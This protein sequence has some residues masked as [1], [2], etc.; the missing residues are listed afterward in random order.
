M[1]PPRRRY[2]ARSAEPEPESVPL[3]KPTDPR[4]DLLDE[5]STRIG[6]EFRDPGL[7]R[8][9]LVHSSM[10]NEGK[11][12]YERLEFLGDAILGF[13]VADHLFRLEPEI[14]EGELTD[15]R[16][17]IVSREPLAAIGTAL[18]LIDYV[19]VGR[20]LRQEE[21]D[22]P[23]LRADL[24]EA[25]LG[26]VYLDGGIR[27]ARRFLRQH[28]LGRI[29]AEPGEDPALGRPRDPKSRL[30]HF[31]QAKAL[32]QPVYSVVATEGPDHAKEF[33][34]AVRIAEAELATG[35][36]RSKQAAQMAAAEAALRIL[37]ARAGEGSEGEGPAGEDPAGEVRPSD[38]SD[39]SDRTAAD[40]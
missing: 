28:V 26:A 12:S 32:G 19:E 27:A 38:P 37:R 25:V 21:L 17:R 16:A 3:T 33:T 35:R 31:A 18:R 34:V 6:H 40:G 20:G 15:R 39:P 24:V 29:G 11:A 7:L 2:P 5:L 22:N 14:P 10:G 23:R 8:R 1:G 4:R 36:A 9:A 30:L 13:M